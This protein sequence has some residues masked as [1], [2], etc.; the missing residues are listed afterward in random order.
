MGVCGMAIAARRPPAFYLLK[1][2]FLSRAN[3]YSAFL[4]LKEETSQ[5]N[6]R[7]S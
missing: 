1:K 2:T 4:R 3:E 7:C 6:M 5:N